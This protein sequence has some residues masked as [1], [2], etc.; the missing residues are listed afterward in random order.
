MQPEP[1]T[2]WNEN[3]L[4]RKNKHIYAHNKSNQI[5]H[6]IRCITWKRITSWRGLSPRHCARATQF[7]SKKCLSGGELMATLCLI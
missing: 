5:L 6:C 1:D 7:L 2:S 3:V 4:G